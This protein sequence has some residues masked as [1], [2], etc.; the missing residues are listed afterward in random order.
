MI[1]ATRVAHLICPQPVGGAE[2][3]VQLLA[4]GRHAAERP[5]EVIAL[6]DLGDSHP[7][8]CAVRAD[9]VP[10]SVFPVMGRR[11]WKASRLV[12][13]TLAERSIAVLHSHV[14]RADFIGYL[15][16]RQSSVRVVSTFHG[17]TGGDLKNRAYEWGVK[18]LLRRFDAVMCVSD[19]TRARLEASGIDASKVSVIP[20]GVA[21]GSSLDRA[22]ARAELG[23]DPADRLVG[24]IGRLSRE[25]GPDLMLSAM[26]SVNGSVPRLRVVFIG[27]GPMRSE[28]EARAREEGVAAG[29]L[30]TISG[31]SRFISAFDVLA[32]SSR[33]EGMPMA[34]LEAMG[35]GVP[36]AAFQ[37]GGIPT[38]LNDETGWPAVPEDVA[39]LGRAIAT[40][41]TNER[42]SRRRSVAAQALIRRNY[43]VSSWVDAVEAIYSTV[44]ARR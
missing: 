10:V 13:R 39:G 27:D 29:F 16:A 41:V 28:L 19:S 35:A 37:V 3:V 14:Y 6:T 21:L 36:V 20:N 5:T 12:A 1:G 7:L 24:W 38:V 17:E 31:A 9:G 2:T 42:E 11:Y 26:S 43:S 22:T 4:I 18:Q 25:K 30:G 33:T 32:M 15:A 8:V 40:A 23:L 34:M 44:L